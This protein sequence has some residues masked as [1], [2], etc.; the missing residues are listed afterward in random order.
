MAQRTLTIDTLGD[1]DN[2][3]A[4]AIVNR[5]IALAVSDLDDR[6]S[7]GKPRKVVITLELTLAD[8]GLVV[9]HVEAQA[10]APAFRT[11][12]TLGKLRRRKDSDQSQI[13]FSQFAPDNPDQETFGEFDPNQPSREE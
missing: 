5:A 13:V 9:G 7:D 4:R 11:H 6:G 2:E 3:A 8:N 12:G 1:L 10:K